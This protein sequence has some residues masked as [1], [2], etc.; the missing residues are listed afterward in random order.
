MEQF[1]LSQGFSQITI[2]P[3]FAPAAESE[4]ELAVMGL[5]DDCNLRC[6]VRMLS[7]L[8]IQFS[9]VVRWYK[10]EVESSVGYK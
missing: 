5:T 10:S 3:E 8:S 7:S 4:E 2:Q 9:A 6:K 1:F